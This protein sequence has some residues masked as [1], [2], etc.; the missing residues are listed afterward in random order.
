MSSSGAA[1]GFP[2]AKA[3]S[4][5]VIAGGSLVADGS[6]DGIEVD[7]GITVGA[8]AQAFRTSRKHKTKDGT[9]SNFFMKTPWI[10]KS[11]SSP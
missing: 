10:G 1:V 4:T 9:K 3:D 6:C 8:V 5:G 11:E 7:I 2:G